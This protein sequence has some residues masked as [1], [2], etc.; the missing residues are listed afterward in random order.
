ME[1]FQL[2]LGSFKRIQ[3]E[4]AFIREVRDMVII[5]EGHI[6]PLV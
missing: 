3:N 2:N 5:G 4:V 6:I 1:V